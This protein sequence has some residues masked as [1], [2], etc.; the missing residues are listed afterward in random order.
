MF[1]MVLATKGMNTVTAAAENLCSL[2]LAAVLIRFQNFHNCVTFESHYTII[3]YH[4]CITYYMYLH[5]CRYSATVRRVSTAL[6]TGAAEQT[7]QSCPN[8]ILA[9]WSLRSLYCQTDL[10][11]WIVFSSVSG[12]KTQLYHVLS[13][14]YLFT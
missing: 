8:W 9:G 5:V 2:H 3:N 11:E 7:Y 4:A 1:G 6:H 13:S 12:R 10:E 14:S